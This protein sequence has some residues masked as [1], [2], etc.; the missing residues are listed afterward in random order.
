MTDN[1]EMLIHQALKRKKF[2]RKN[3]KIEE[4]DDLYT[5][6]IFNNFNPTNFQNG[7]DLISIIF[8]TLRIANI[9]PLSIQ[10]MYEIN[11]SQKKIEYF[12]IQIDKKDY[13]NGISYL[14]DFLNL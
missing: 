13:L 6:T 4:I 1:V 3:I 2:A 7:F 5:I 8:N 9:Y 10:P 11:N 12:Y 14:N